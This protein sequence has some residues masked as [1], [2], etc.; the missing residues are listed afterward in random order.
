MAGKSLLK[1]VQLPDRQMTAWQGYGIDCSR[2][3]R[4]II[5]RIQRLATEVHNY[6]IC[7]L[8]AIEIL[9][10]LTNENSHFDIIDHF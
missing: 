4:Y 1:N 8:K 3:S 9:G 2:L 5:L 10:Q 7:G 6:F